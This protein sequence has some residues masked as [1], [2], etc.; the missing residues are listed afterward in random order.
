MDI[1]IT[2]FKCLYLWY[3]NGHAMFFLCANVICSNVAVCRCRY[4]NTAFACRPACAL[5]VLIAVLGPSL[6]NSAGRAVEWNYKSQ[7][8]APQNNPIISHHGASWTVRNVTNMNWGVRTSYQAIMRHGGTIVAMATWRQWSV[9]LC[10]S[11]IYCLRQSIQVHHKLVIMKWRLL[12][13]YSDVKKRSFK[14]LDHEKV[15]F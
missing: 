10:W 1:D 6:V 2:L 12:Q 9:D 15:W 5:R 7:F 3:A 13:T 14:P 4:Q 11:P 8:I